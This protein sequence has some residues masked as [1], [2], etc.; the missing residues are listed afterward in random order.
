MRNVNLGLLILRLS[1]A[2]LMLPH[3]IAK[4]F[5]GVGHI[6]GLFNEMGMPEFFAYSVYLG[7]VIVPILIIIG[8]RT[9]LASIFFAITCIVAMLLAHSDQLF[10][11]G[12]GGG[13]SQ[14]LLGLFLFGSIALFFTGAGK[15]A[16]STKNKWD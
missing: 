9:R 3:G 7:E 6:K 2:G 15:Y 11:L 8:F 1:V 5:K 14:E 4:L 13:W 10:S 16:L 12:K